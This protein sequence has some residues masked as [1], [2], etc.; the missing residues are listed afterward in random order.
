M[1]VGIFPDC[2]AAAELSIESLSVD[3]DSFE[4]YAGVEAHEVTEAELKQQMA[5]GHIAAFDTV[6]QL[7]AFVNGDPVLSKLG[8]IIKVRNGK[9]TVRMILDTTASG[10]KYVTGKSQRVIL[11]GLFD[12]VLRLLALLTESHK[13]GGE[14]GAFVLDFSDAF[15]QIP[16]A[17]NE[18]RFFCATSLIDQIRKY[19][20]FLRAAQGS[21]AAPLLWA[22]LAALLMRLTQSLFKPT[23]VNLMCFVDDPLAALRGSE[24]ERNTHA[25]MIML[26]WEALDFKLAYHKG[27]LAK[28]VTWIGGTLACE[29]AG[30]RAS[31]KTAIVD[32]IKDDLRKFIKSNV[33]SHK[34]L[35]SLVGKPGHCAGLLI[36]MRPF[37]QP[38]WAALYSDAPTASPHNT[39]WTKQIAAT[40]QWFSAF[41]DGAV[42]GA[43]ASTPSLG[44]WADGCHTMATSPI[45]FPAPSPAMMKPYT[46]T[47]LAAPRASR[48][49]SALRF[50][51]P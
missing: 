17:D 7:R 47:V 14:V 40:L 29:A 42:G 22:R 34:D 9:I 33:I 13:N 49:G 45:T 50:S 36:T 21:R 31:V 39:V 26:V 35:H 16:I 1:N 19:I 24:L 4:N 38:L 10:I 12:A 3:C 18:L 28:T 6:A 15:W 37:L 43:S 41:F 23:E 27:Q 32:D 44:G 2:S 11:P 25:A 5:K 20:V 46:V 51:S 48:S 30:V 8:L